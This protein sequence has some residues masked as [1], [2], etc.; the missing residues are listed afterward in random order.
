MG[1]IPNKKRKKESKTIDKKTKKKK[2]PHNN[3]KKFLK[4]ILKLTA[5]IENNKSLNNYLNK[6]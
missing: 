4:K 2:F 6:L 5:L 1:Q 3:G